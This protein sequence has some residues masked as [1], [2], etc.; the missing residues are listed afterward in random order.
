VV[1]GLADAGEP[2]ADAGVILASAVAD[3]AARG[4]L[5]PQSGQLPIAALRRMR[6]PLQRADQL[7]TAA[8]GLVAE[9]PDDGFL[10]PIGD[11]RQ[12][13]L[14][15]LD[16]AGQA[17]H[18]GAAVARHLPLFLGG[19]EKRRYFFGASSPAEARGTGGFIGAYT[20]LTVRNGRLRFG[21]FASTGDLPTVPPGEIPPPNADYAARY[22]RYGGAGFWQNLNLTPDFPSAATAIE[23]LYERVRSDRVD[24]TIVA[25]PH[26]LE[27]LLRL[28]GPADV[29]LVGTVTADTVVDVL[30]N[31]AYTRFTDP[32]ERKQVLGAVA[33]SVLE[34]F[35]SGSGDPSFP[36]VAQ[37]LAD[38]AAGSHLLLHARDK[39]IQAAFEEV[40]VAGQ[41]LDPSGDYVSVVVNNAAGNKIDYY[42]RR[43]V[44]YEAVLAKDGSVM[45]SLSVQLDN[46]APAQGDPYIIGPFREG[47]R[48]GEN[49]S[50]VSVFGADSSELSS[51]TVDRELASVRPER[52][53]GHPV[54]TDTVRIA[55]KDSTELGYKWVLEGGWDGDLNAGIY[56]LTV[57]GQTTPNPTGL[58]LAIDPPPGVTVTQMSPGLEMRGGRLVYDGP[59]RDRLEF[60]I[61]FGRPLAARLWARV[62]RFLSQPL[63]GSA[64][65]RPAWPS[66]V[67]GSSFQSRHFMLYCPDPRA[68]C[69]Q[70]PND[71]LVLRPWKVQNNEAT[72]SPTRH[73]GIAGP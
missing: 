46:D 10:Q 55:S 31:E 25:D 11:A 30:S 2:S 47:F 9:T 27:A 33:A 58:M 49:V 20:I 32:R 45:G 64:R 23:N 16:Q 54:W 63:I 38:A 26:A 6:H 56:R 1:R 18:A 22:D 34:R 62:R 24:G 70:T 28:T 29:P 53:L 13:L 14:A 5:R 21:E 15:N 39:D 50:L 57:Q 4:D 59:L 12:A 17:V 73:L 36:R 7:L 40:G 66:E 51:Y 65:P 68:R 41:L 69:G 60:E 67:H 48:A 71:C 52:E 37:A 3:I 8:R 35:L 19:T 42:A 72:G 43:R 61:S 44:R